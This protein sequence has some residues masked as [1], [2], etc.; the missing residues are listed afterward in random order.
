MSEDQLKLN[1]RL[2]LQHT[3]V[4]AAATGTWHS[5]ALKTDAVEVTVVREDAGDDNNVIPYIYSRP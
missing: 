2:F 5:V 4:A 1:R 3:A